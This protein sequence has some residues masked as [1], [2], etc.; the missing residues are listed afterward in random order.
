MATQKDYQD[1]LDRI[2]KLREVVAAQLSPQLAN[3]PQL[4]EIVSNQIDQ[5]LESVVATEASTP[6]PPDFGLTNLIGIGPQPATSPTDAYVTF[7]V[8]R[9]DDVVSSERA[10]AV[11]DLYYIY[12]H[13]HV[14]VFRAVDTLRELFVT[15]K[16]KLSAGPGALGLYRLAAKDALRYSKKARFT[17]YSR[18]FG[19]AAGATGTARVNRDFHPLFVKFIRETA[20]Y[21]EGK[22][23]ANVIQQAQGADTIGS[24]AFVRRAALDCAYNVN[25]S[26]FG[27][28]NVLRVESM[29]LLDEGFRILDAPD[30]KNLFGSQSAWDVAE[31]VLHRY[32]NENPNTSARQRLATAGRDILRWLAQAQTLKM[33]RAEFEAR[34]IEISDACD[35]WLTSAESLGVVGSAR[36]GGRVLAYQ[37]RAVAAAAA[38]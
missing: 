15:G 32:H 6:P 27:N 20:R 35:E 18:V 28:V 3:N 11:A 5:M 7:E 26:S 14:G 22:R 1:L 31:E 9:Y 23:L 19:Y 8:N 30:V 4:A 24:L 36:R 29:Q 25:V 2:G 12:Q 34:L 17:A 38:T 37:P 16:V 33:A 10:N 13:E 21:W